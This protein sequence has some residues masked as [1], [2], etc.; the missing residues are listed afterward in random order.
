MLQ[1]RAKVA[2]KVGAKN[3]KIVKELGTKNLQN[4]GP[5]PPKSS[6]EG[7]K[8]EPG[9]PEN[10]KKKTDPTKTSPGGNPPAVF[11]AKKWPTWLQVG[12]QNR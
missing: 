9:H 6:P 5:N 8:K 1:H 12:L 11:C 10:R 2:E 3:L 4:G 7:A